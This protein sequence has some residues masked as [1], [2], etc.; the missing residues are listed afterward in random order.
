MQ[1]TRPPALSA[2][3]ACRIVALL[4]IL[5]GAAQAR[6]AAGEWI[7]ER[8]NCAVRLPSS[9]GWTYT[10]GNSPTTAGV[11]GRETASPRRLTFTAVLTTGGATAEETITGLEGLFREGLPPAAG[12][13]AQLQPRVRKFSFAGFP[14]IELSC[15][16]GTEAAP[17][18]IV[19][20]HIVTGSIAYSMSCTT[21][22][23]TLR[24]DSELAAFTD[25]FRFLRPPAAAHPA[26][27]S[28]RTVM[29]AGG[30]A[31]AAGLAAMAVV[32]TRRRRPNS[33]RASSD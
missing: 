24:E 6:T 22:A 5:G 3:A 32:L 9:D 14:G 4:A 16:V 19:E 1:T 7:S 18:T 15:R 10:E 8:W 26:P 2:A 17:L 29:I 13:D 33:D 20:K 28:S 30:L 27:G 11:N 31:V 23:P 25:S 12:L 21:S